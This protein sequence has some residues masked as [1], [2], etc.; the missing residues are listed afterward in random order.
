[1][2][3]VLGQIQKAMLMVSIILT[4]QVQTCNEELKRESDFTV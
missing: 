4:F 2:N 3:W 1:M